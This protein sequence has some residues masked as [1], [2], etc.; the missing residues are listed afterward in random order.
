MNA[1]IV[2]AKNQ[3]GELAR[4]SG[5]VAAKGINIQAGSVLSLGAIGGFG[6]I[7]NDESGTRS[8]L[9]GAQAT[10]RE[11]EVI[12]ITVPDEPG[13]LAEI[14]RKL[15]DAGINVELLLATGMSGGKMNLALGVDK[16]EAARGIIGVGTAAP[17]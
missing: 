14:A 8:A 2:E 3:P 4:V 1:F 10:Y 7:T 17:A 5:A 6:F 16:V 11:V 12:P 15:G 9:D 13:A